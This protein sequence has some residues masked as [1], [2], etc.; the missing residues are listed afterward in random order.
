M[1]YVIDESQVLKCMQVIRPNTASIQGRNENIEK[2]YSIWEGESPWLAY[3]TW[4]PNGQYEEQKMLSPKA[5]RYFTRA[6]AN[7]YAN[8]NVNITLPNEEN[9]KMLREILTDNKFF[10]KFNNHIDSTFGVGVGAIVISKSGGYTTKR[11]THDIVKD[12]SEVEI[13]FIGGRRVVPIT[14]EDGKVTECAFLGFDTRVQ[15]I[16]IHYLNENGK[17]DIAMFKGVSN[18]AKTAYEMNYTPEIIHV[19]S[20]YPLFSIWHPNIAEEDDFDSIIGTSVFHDATDALQQIDLDYTTLYKEVQLGKKTKFISSGLI[21]KDENGNPQR[22]IDVNDE[23]IIE[24]PDSMAGKVNMQEF[25][26][27]LRI[28]PLIAALNINLNVAAMLCGLG[29][30]TFEF[31][32]SG[33][34]IQ[35]ATGVIAKQTELYRNVIKQENF[36]REELKHLIQSI[37]W[38]HNTWTTKPSFVMTIE[39]ENGAIRDFKLSDISI[40]FDDN[41]V[42]DTSSRREHELAEVNAGT[43]TIAE[44]RSHWYGESIEAAKQFVQENGLLLM[45]Y[46]DAYNSGAM[47]EEQFVDLCYGKECENRQAIIESLRAKKES[48]IEDFKIDEE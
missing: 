46:L 19:N 25:N 2:Y 33:R 40:E 1:K 47:T 22:L 13:K 21:N 34:P 26:G 39:D 17:Y 9:D 29:Q 20:P 4:M 11:K 41:I 24:I 7:N 5:A 42:E 45:K 8:E 43:M 44:Y 27:D 15:T 3:K 23:T 14:V 35:T 28:Q 36:A 18:Q 30:S 6:W 38:L 10:S 12:D 37:I 32:S 31:E 16:V 48:P